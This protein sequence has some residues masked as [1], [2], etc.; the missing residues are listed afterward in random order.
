MWYILDL[1]SDLG[2]SMKNVTNALKPDT[3]WH[4][5]GIQL[6]VPDDELMQS[7]R[8]QLPQRQLSEMLSYWFHNAKE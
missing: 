2:L 6:G 5:L 3:V 1:F 4:N 7:D 8:K